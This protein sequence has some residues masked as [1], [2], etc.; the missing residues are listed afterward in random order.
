M[1]SPDFGGVIAKLLVALNPITYSDTRVWPSTTYYYRVLA[2]NTAGSTPSNTASATTGV[3]DFIV[4]IATDGGQNVDSNTPNTLSYAISHATTGKSI[5][6]TVASVTVNG[7]L[8]AVPAGVTIYGGKCGTT[9]V[10]I[11]AGATY[12]VN[13]VTNGLVLSGGNVLVNLKVSGFPGVQLV[14]GPGGQNNLQCV[15]VSKV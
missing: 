3:A 15:S 7:Q 1:T 4:S 12:P 8:Q 14:A 2:F 11:K 5:G 6:F 13:P 9:Q 10:N